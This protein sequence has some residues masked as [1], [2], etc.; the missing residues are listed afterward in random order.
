MRLIKLIIILLIISLV[1]SRGK[2]IPMFTASFNAI[3]PIIS[4]GLQRQTLVN[5]DKITQD[6]AKLKERIRR[7]V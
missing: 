1:A 7:N 3:S 4:Q 2:A 6:I 5:V